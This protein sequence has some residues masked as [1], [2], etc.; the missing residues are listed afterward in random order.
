MKTIH[1][2]FENGI[3]RPTEPVDLPEGSEVTVEPKSHPGAP[4]LSVHQ[5]RIRELLRQPIGTGDPGLSE[6]HNEHQP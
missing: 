3:F 4:E 6:R 2:I 1:A 5:K